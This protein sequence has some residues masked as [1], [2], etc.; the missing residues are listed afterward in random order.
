MNTFYP[1]VHCT[2]FPD[3]G[4]I[5]FYKSDH[6]ENLKKHVKYAWNNDKKYSKYT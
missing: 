4:V 1:G 3:S 5:S 2:Q 6:Y